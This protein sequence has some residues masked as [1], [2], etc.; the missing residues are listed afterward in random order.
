MTISV[1]R[2][3]AVLVPYEPERPGDE[4]AMV[5]GLALGYVRSQRLPRRGANAPGEQ[6]IRRPGTTL[7]SPSREGEF[8][9][10]YNIARIYGM[11][12]KNC[13]ISILR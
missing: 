13:R 5:D 11:L 2:H 10:D 7:V 8:T 4:N 9:A 6:D 12:A 3:R 1:V